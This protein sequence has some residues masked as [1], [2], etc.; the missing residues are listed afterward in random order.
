MESSSPFIKEC[1][2]LLMAVRYLLS[3][4]ARLNRVMVFFFAMILTAPYACTPSPY[5]TEEELFS[6][7][8]DSNEAAILFSFD[9]NLAPHPMETLESEQEDYRLYRIYFPDR[10]DS[11]FP[12]KGLDAFEYRPKKKNRHSGMGIILLPIQGGDYEVST[13]FADYFVSKGFS[14]LRFSRRAE[15]LV[16]ERPFSSLALLF[17]EY[18]IDIRRGLEW[19]KESGHVDADRVGLFGVSMGAIVGSVVT[20]LECPSLRAS[21][22]VLGGSSLADIL[23]TADDEEINEI[24]RIWLERF[25]NQKDI[26]SRELHNA[27]DPVNPLRIASR[28]CIPSTLMIHARFDAVVRYPLSTA[29]WE[30][31]GKPDRITIPTGHYSSVF[32]IHYIRWKACRWF[33]QRLLHKQITRTHKG[34]GVT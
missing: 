14:C 29:I 12:G 24:R 28:I 19:W 10:P 34:A 3:N 1:K 2:P 8:A 33:D 22:L 25:N 23:L 7:E 20:A 27:L 6:L 17:R 21:V 30:A 5:M 13:Y 18:V 9:K 16:P 4:R 32:L 31:A 26:L 15:W 11:L